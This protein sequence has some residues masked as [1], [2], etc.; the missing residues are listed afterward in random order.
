MMYPKGSLK[1]GHK[2]GIPEVDPTRGSQIGHPRGI[3]KGWSPRVSPAGGPQERFHM[4][5]SQGDITRWFPKWASTRGVY[6]RV[7]SE[8]IHNGDPPVCPQRGSPY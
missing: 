7:T 4:G 3:S 2:R 5:I 6:S 1:G 8:L